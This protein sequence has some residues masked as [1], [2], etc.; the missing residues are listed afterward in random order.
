MYLVAKFEFSCSG[1]NLIKYLINKVL[2]ILKTKLMFFSI[3]IWFKI[4]GPK[5]SGN[6]KLFRVL[7]K[8]ITC[9]TL[10]NKN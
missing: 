8:K 1:G 6:D 10:A 3:M 5:V 4:Y 2:K 9:R 7:R